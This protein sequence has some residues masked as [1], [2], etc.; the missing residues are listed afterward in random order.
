MQTVFV[1]LDV[2]EE[3]LAQA[4]EAGAD[5][6][7]THHPLLFS[8]VKKITDRDFM[9]RRILTLIEKQITY[10]AMH[11]NFDVTGMAKLNVQALE[12]EGQKH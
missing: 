1:A 11:T 2:T 6:M 12:L 8:P 3:T 10:Y 7:V 9:G 4:A 5:L